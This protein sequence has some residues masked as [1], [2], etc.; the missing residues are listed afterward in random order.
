M[1]PE[2]LE[3]VALT[4]VGRRTNF[5]AVSRSERRSW[6]GARFGDP[7]VVLKSLV[8]VNVGAYARADAGVRRGCGDT[9]RSETDESAKLLWRTRNP[10]SRKKSA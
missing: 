3:S 7:R 5:R 1:P 9:C 4:E 6:S 8:R 10:A 2:Q